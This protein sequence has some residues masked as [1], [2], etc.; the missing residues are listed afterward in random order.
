MPDAPQNPQS[1]R[2]LLNAG[3]F[4]TLESSMAGQTGIENLFTA[5]QANA[6]LLN[7]CLAEARSVLRG[8]MPAR[9]RLWLLLRG[10]AG[11]SSIDIPR[12][13]LAP[14]A[15]PPQLLDG[16]ALLDLVIGTVR[17]ANDEDEAGA[18]LGALGSLLNPL[19]LL[20]HAATAQLAGRVET[21]QT[22][23]A[24]AQSASWERLNNATP[25]QALDWKDRV[26]FDMGA[27]HPPINFGRSI[28]EWSYLWYCLTHHVGYSE[29][30]PFAAPYNIDSISDPAA[31]P[32]TT[33]FIR[34]SG[35]GPEGRVYF[36]TPS[37]TDPAFQKYAGDDGILVGVDA[38]SWTDTLIE[39]VVPPW[40][41]SG[42]LHLNAFTR[43]ETPCATQ[44]V[45]RLGN[46]VPF[47]GGLAS[48]YAISLNGQPVDLNYPARQTFAPDD[49]I[50]LSWQASVGPTVRVSIS[51]QEKESGKVLWTAPGTFAGG[52]Q[53]TPVPI[54]DPGQ[55]TIA[56]FVISATS[57]CGHA[58]PLTVDFVISVVPVV[59]ISFIEVTQGVQTD[60]TT[61]L[62][63][64]AMPLVAGKDTG[65]RV[66]LTVD[67]HGWFND[68]LANITGAVTVSGGGADA[69]T[70]APLNKRPVIPDAGFV[71]VTVSSHEDDDYS[72][73]NF[74]IPGAACNGSRTITAGI[75]SGSDPSGPVRLAASIPWTWVSRPVIRLR[76]IILNPPDYTYGLVPML[77]PYLSSALDYLPTITSDVGPAW[78]TQYNHYY[79]FSKQDGWDNALDDLSSFKDCTIWD[80]LNPF[81]DHCSSADDGAIWVGIVPP[82]ADP[83][84]S[85]ELGEGKPGETCIAVTGRPDVV[86]HEIGHTFGFNHVNLTFQ[87]QNIDGPYDT[88]DNGGYH[89][90]PGFDV[91]AGKIIVRSAGVIDNHGGSSTNPADLMSYLTP[92]WFTTTN[93]LRMFNR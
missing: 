32:G 10:A 64:G 45:Y 15:A 62:Q 86:A 19:F 49:T 11:L 81:A 83:S 54:P 36:P 52:L 93:W 31:C 9:D 84:G 18:M 44:D 39:V 25:T 56:Q 87:G 16:G 60:Q 37:A 88:V 46:S 23:A 59:N 53:A 22:I 20:D 6:S 66:Y 71:D 40:A 28:S 34:G 13:I 2:P 35:F 78:T 82:S 79:D 65:V 72:T 51:T 50:A 43:I 24:A 68:K 41:V 90:R 27:P 1:P 57:D 33:I 30:D 67:R 14:N 8:N 55:P 75:Y 92:L 12:D 91:H 5:A 29:I 61:Q 63:G 77:T 80:Q 48:V 21:I 47:T 70:V 69:I 17:S 73:L 3:A 58:G 76:W 42:D 26:G 38:V 85:P 89:R 74:V 4:S 7:S